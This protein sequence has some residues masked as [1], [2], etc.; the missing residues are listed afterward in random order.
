MARKVR[1]KGTGASDPWQEVGFFGFPGLD[2]GTTDG[3]RLRVTETGRVLAELALRNET[4]L[5]D[6]KPSEEDEEAG[7]GTDILSADLRV[8][9]AEGRLWLATAS[10]D[11]GVFVS[12]LIDVARKATIPFRDDAA[13][14]RKKTKGGGPAPVL[15]DV[16]FWSDD[17]FIRPI[18][19][20][21]PDGEQDEHRI[22]QLQF[23]YTLLSFDVAYHR[24]APEIE[25]LRHLLELR[26]RLDEVGVFDY[27]TVE[28]FGPLAFFFSWEVLFQNNHWSR[29][30]DG[31]WRHSTLPLPLVFRSVDGSGTPQAQVVVA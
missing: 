20:Y 7:L 2:Y 16:R 21:G 25:V 4:R 29:D 9:D 10:F 27:E 24:P 13:R 17:R 12:Q 18:V 22:V 31:R 6:Q 28:E 26:V 19:F 11:A 30:R 15:T 1:G 23:K 8:A 3:R 14:G 5:V